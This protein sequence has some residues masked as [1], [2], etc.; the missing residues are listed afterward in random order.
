MEHYLRLPRQPPRGCWNF[1]PKPELSNLRGT[2]LLANAAMPVTAPIPRPS[3][4]STAL[5]TTPKSP[6]RGPVLMA[7]AAPNACIRTLPDSFASSSRHKS[8][9]SRVIGREAPALDL[10]YFIFRRLNND[11]SRRKG[12]Y[13]RP[14]VWNGCPRHS[15]EPGLPSLSESR[16]SYRLPGLLKLVGWPGLEPGTNGLKGL[17]EK[18]IPYLIL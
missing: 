18:C 9:K 17:R 8:T 3:T 5:T 7:K 11:L 1:V 4:S 14:A 13:R 16:E 10:F 2:L 12:G 15:D 6:L